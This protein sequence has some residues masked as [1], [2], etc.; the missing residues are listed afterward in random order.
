MSKLDYLVQMLRQELP[1]L[2][3]CTAGSHSAPLSPQALQLCM[4]L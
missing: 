3:G 2:Q 4:Y 1:V